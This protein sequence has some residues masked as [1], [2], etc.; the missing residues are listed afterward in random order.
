MFSRD[1]TRIF[2][3]SLLIKNYIARLNPRKAYIVVDICWLIHYSY[4][5]GK[6]IVEILCNI[7]INAITPFKLIEI[8]AY[9]GVEITDKSSPYF[10]E[11][12]IN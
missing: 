1:F 11:R 4:A 8:H 3:S 5:F 9:I 2:N 12:G 7:G 6:P 10:R